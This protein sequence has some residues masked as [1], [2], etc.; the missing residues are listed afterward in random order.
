MIAIGFL[1]KTWQGVVI[2]AQ[3]C[4]LIQS[5]YIMQSTEKVYCNNKILSRNQIMRDGWKDRQP[6]SNIVPTFSKRSGTNVRK[7]TC[8]NPNLDLVNMKAYKIW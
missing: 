4:S 7:M 6:K 5:K 8:Y 1:I 3:L 2:P